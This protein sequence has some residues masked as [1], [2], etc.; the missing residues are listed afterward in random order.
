MTGTVHALVGAALGALLRRPGVAFVGGVLS[1]SLL[2][3]L[4]HKDYDRSVG[5]I[6][7][8]LGLLTVLSLAARAGRP[9]IVAGAI[10]GLLPD[11]E[12]IIP[13]NEHRMPKV[14]PSHWFRHQDRV[15]EQAAAIELTVGAAAVGMLI[16]TRYAG[17]RRSG[18]PAPRAGGNIR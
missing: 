10:G 3:C 9:E 16:A 4:P 18:S 2:D 5:L 17:S 12:N 14:F 13:G 6:P 15:T 7:D 8:I 11:V 1:H